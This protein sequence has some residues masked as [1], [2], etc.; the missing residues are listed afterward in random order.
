MRF[1]FYCTILL[2]SLSSSC[3]TS[4]FQTIKCNSEL[5]F[6]SNYIL[7]DNDSLVQ[8][9]IKGQLEKNVLGEN[10]MI[11]LDAISYIKCNEGGIKH[12]PISK[13][14]ISE[15]SVLGGSQAVPLYGKQ[16]SSGIVLITS[17]AF[18]EAQKQN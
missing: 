14:E 6:T 17:K 4:Q 3:K 13:P 10:P 9:I 18:D 1:T 2:L 7:K 12:I 15:I 16:A 5:A 11:V 8:D